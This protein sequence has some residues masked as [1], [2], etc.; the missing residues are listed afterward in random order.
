MW[1]EVTKALEENRR[2]L[3]LEGSKVAKRVAD[4]GVDSRIFS[5][6]ELNFLRLSG[7]CLTT[8]DSQVCQLAEKLTD[9]DLHNN[10]IEEI[11]S[12]LSQLHSLKTLNLSGNK[13]QHLP[14]AVRNI[15]SLLTLNVSHNLIETIGDIS[16]LGKLHELYV[17]GNKLSSLPDGVETLESLLVV[18]ADHNQ[19][20][21][22]PEDIHKLHHLKSLHMTDNCLSSLPLSIVLLDKLRVLDLRANKFTDRRLLKLANV[23][24]TQPKGIFKYLKPLYEKES[25]SKKGGEYISSM[26]AVS[27]LVKHKLEKSDV[28]KRASL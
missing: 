15:G 9:L 17:N 23:D 26:A 28:P 7:T 14:D 11:P 10:A 19:I 20:E 1:P 24:Q 6:K 13:L 27:F 2:E 18:Q 3:L 25:T 21:A 4:E 5:L 12:E 16:G 22:L 8:L